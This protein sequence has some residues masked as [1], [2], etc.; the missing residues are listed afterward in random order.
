MPHESSPPLYF[1]SRCSNSASP[2]RIPAILSHSNTRARARFSFD[3]HLPFSLLRHCCFVAAT[4]I[5]ARIYPCTY[6]IACA[7]VLSIPYQQSGAP[8]GRSEYRA[9]YYSESIALR[10]R[11][12]KGNRANLTRLRPRITRG[13]TPRSPR[14]NDAERRS[15]QEISPSSRSTDTPGNRDKS[16]RRR[17]EVLG[18]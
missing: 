1:V 3:S 5:R 12:G 17:R 13:E 4:L 10:S 6:G 2:G 15:L 14:G 9:D 8:A 7:C 16:L 11:A 18:S